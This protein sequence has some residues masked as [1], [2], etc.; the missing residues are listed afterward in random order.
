MEERV[1]VA[2]VR[3][4]EDILWLTANLPA[5]CCLHGMSLPE[6]FAR[7]MADAA[8]RYADVLRIDLARCSQFHCVDLC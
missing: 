5:S 2:S 4:M 6:M 3:T 1:R 8:Q 7:H